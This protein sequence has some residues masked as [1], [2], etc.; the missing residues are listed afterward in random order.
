M[1]ESIQNPSGDTIDYTFHDGAEGARKTRIKPYPWASSDASA[2]SSA[3][4][5]SFFVGGASGSRGRFVS[6]L[7]MTRRVAVRS[8]TERK[9][10]GDTRKNQSP[11]DRVS[12]AYA[13]RAMRICALLYPPGVGRGAARERLG[14]ARLPGT[15]ARTFWDM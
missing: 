4:N 12:R 1:I 14:D 13:S 15:R 10:K 9:E 7:T 11:V 6:T 5:C 2:A 8:S 3:D